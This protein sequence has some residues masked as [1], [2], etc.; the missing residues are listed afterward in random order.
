MNRRVRRSGRMI[1][2]GVSLLVFGWVVSPASGQTP[3]RGGWLNVALDSSA[4]GLDPHLTDADSTYRFVEPVYDTLLRHNFKMELEPSLAT[5]YDHPNDLTYVFTLRKGVKFHNGLEMTS[6]DIKFT[7][8]RLMDPKTGAP[9]R[10]MFN[11]IKSVETP[12]KYTV[13]VTLKD[14]MPGFL[15]LCSSVRYTA[16][17]SKAE[18]QKQGTLQKTMCGTGPFRLMEYTHGVGATYE[19]NPDY[20]EPG[21]PY[22][23]GF[24]L[25]V[26]KDESSRVASIRKG[27]ADIA[28]FNDVQS[29]KQL[30]KE[31]N[32]STIIPAKACQGRFWLNHRSFPFNNMKLRQAVSACLDRQMMVDKI[33]FGYG[34]ISA[35]V[36][37]AATP[38]ALSKEEVANLPFYKQDYDLAKKLL[39]EAGYPDGFEFTL[40]TSPRNEE[41]VAMAQ[42]I[43]EQLSKAGIKAKIELLEWT[44]FQ[45]IVKRRGDWQAQYRDGGW[46]DDPASYFYEFMYGK[47]NEI[48]QND[49]EINQLM[50][51]CYTTDNLEKRKQYFKDLQYKAA[52]KAIAMFPFAKPI[53]YEVVNKKVKGYYFLPD[54]GRIYLRQTWIE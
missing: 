37:P 49:P 30:E 33:L 2:L 31:P 22:L 52:E 38:F 25:I 5:S 39:K 14:T 20:W 27:T 45:T 51:L 6:E 19:R 3:K 10:E 36:P 48:G 28:W 16:I 18:V 17:V 15:A 26:V 4:V 50:Q 21:I 44:A 54:S 34:E 43:Q 1:L 11:P 42:I 35:I 29:M 46:R 32:L 24:K 53:W 23:D 8:D 9:K 47:D 40:K 41:Y 7:F 13:K 12:D